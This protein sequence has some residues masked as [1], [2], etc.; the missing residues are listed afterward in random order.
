MRTRLHTT[1]A[2]ACL[3]LFMVVLVSPA[4][5]ETKTETFRTGPITVAGYQVK[6]EQAMRIPKPDVNGYITDMSVD[7]VDKDGTPVPISRL[8]LHHIVFLNVGKKDA[9]CDEFTLLDSKTKVSG[10]LAERFYAAGEERAV[11]KLPEGHGYPI[12][13]KDPWLMT[14]MMMNHRRVTDQAYI[15]Y[16]V[17]YTDEA[18]TT[19]VK[20]YWLDSR[21]CKS[22]PVYDVPGGGKPGSIHTD[23]K[24]FTMPE[25]GRIVAGGGH[26]H[27]GARDLTLR[28][29]SCADRRLFASK[30]LWG[31]K[32]H[33]FY[34]VQP[35]LHEPGPV[36][37]SGF[38]SKRGFA[39]PAGQKLVLESNYD[40]ER[41]HTRVMGIMIVYVAHDAAAT[42]A[43]QA[44][45][46]ACAPRPEDI[47]IFR[48]EANGRFRA[49]LFTV[50]LTGIDPR[51]S[52]AREIERPPGPTKVL[53]GNPMLDVESFSLKPGNVSIPRG[54]TVAWRF[55]GSDL[56]DITVANGPRGF[57]TPHLN[58]NRV[59][60]RQ[61]NTPGTYKMFCSLHPVDMTQTV[62]VR[63]APKG[64]RSGLPPLPPVGI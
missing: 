24:T 61:F 25:D 59:F 26:V 5:A 52:L 30:P 19:P 27:G 15:E 55:R 63:K 46:G 38:L 49:P 33:P 34:N 45:D 32:D 21:N 3:A 39:V 2:A 6:Q 64:A 28:Q 20:P 12:A 4:A 8:M 1:M 57:S 31:A 44:E 50:P 17:T 54:G 9:T 13:K 35:V 10:S 29:A 40:A 48:S 7:V 43:A 47:Q 36:N 60:R 14:W 37:M 22:D 23:R 41:L 51:T 58:G 42:A 18:S 11:F 62:T 53:T 56:H 16:K